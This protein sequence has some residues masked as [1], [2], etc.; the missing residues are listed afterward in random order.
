MPSSDGAVAP[1]PDLTGRKEKVLM[2][3]WLADLWCV[4]VH[5]RAMWPV[6]GKYICSR[7]LREYP[8]LW[9][10]CR[11][12]NVARGPEPQAPI[13]SPYRIV[14]RENAWADCDQ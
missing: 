9:E 11:V 10:D 14:S 5:R 13:N 7:C 8:V 2:F 12:G 3:K 4:Q 1:F 6:N